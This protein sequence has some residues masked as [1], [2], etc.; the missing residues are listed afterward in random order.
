MSDAYRADLAF[1]HDAGFGRV[2]QE[3]AGLLVGALRDRGIGR[4]LVV[5]LGCGSGILSQIVS[6]AGYSVL[7]IDISAA[8]IEL[9]RTR[10]PQGEFRTE[11]LLSAEL[12]RCVAVA[13]VGEG[14][15]YLFDET[16]SLAS[17]ESLFGRVFREL[18]PGGTLLLDAAGPG[19]VPG[20]ISRLGAQEGDGWAVLFRSEESPDG[21]LTRSITSF[22]RVGEL[23]RRDREIHRQRLIEPKQ[24]GDLLG[25]AGFSVR[26][27]AGY[28]EERFPPGLTGFR[29][30]KPT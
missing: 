8:M 12:P 18:E 1:I 3:A 9:A 11:S 15:N 22:R 25:V 16:H 24:L 23:Y 6:A 26:V 5:D 17:L 13:I 7:G 30:E 19:R 4:G 21:I 29:A 20:G 28:G 14:L 2:A 10:V 27:L